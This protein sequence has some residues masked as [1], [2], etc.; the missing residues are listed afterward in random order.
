MTNRMLNISQQ[1]TAR[2]LGDQ[3]T[4]SWRAALENG[5]LQAASA[6]IAGAM[7]V[8]NPLLKGL[9]GKF[10]LNPIEGM[11]FNLALQITQLATGQ[12]HRFDWK[13]IENRINTNFL[14]QIDAIL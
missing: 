14:C 3:G 12:T 7:N 1:E 5:E 13:Q 11:G 6:G 8:A 4:F 9:N 10:I 2:A